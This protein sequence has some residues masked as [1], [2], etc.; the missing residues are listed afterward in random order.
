MTSRLQPA[1]CATMNRSTGF[2]PLAGDQSPLEVFTDYAIRLFTVLQAWNDRA[3]QRHHLRPSVLRWPIE[4]QRQRPASE[5]G[6]GGPTPRWTLP[7][8][9]GRVSSG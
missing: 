1:T 8:L 3:R 9:L 6:T 5:P 7:G 4:G 2:S